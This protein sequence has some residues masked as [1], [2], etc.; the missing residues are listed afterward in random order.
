MFIPHSLL[1]SSF[2]TNKQ[3]WKRP[4][5]YQGECQGKAGTISWPLGVCVLQLPAGDLGTLP[6]C[7]LSHPTFET[8]IPG[9]CVLFWH[10]A[11]SSQTFFFN[12]FG[13]QQN[14]TEN[15]LWL[16]PALWFRE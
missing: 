4:R 12:V 7:L 10:G 1:L 8:S 16:L 11:E 5:Y 9:L 6:L 15:S 3:K 2:K 13:P 14:A